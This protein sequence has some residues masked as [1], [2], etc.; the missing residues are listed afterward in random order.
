MVVK[1]VY[2]LFGFVEM[3]QVVVD[4]YIGQIFI[5]CVVQ[6]YCGDGRIYVVGEIEDY[7][8]VVYLFV[9]VCYGVVDDFCWC[10]QCFIL[11]DI[12]Y[13]MFQYVYILVGVGY[14]WVELYIV[15]VFFFVGYNGEWVVFGVGD[16]YEVGWNCCYFIVVVYLYVQQWFVVC[17]Q[18]IF[19]IV[20]QCVV[21]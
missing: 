1:Y 16:G 19:N 10:L 13:K 4:E 17:G 20:N 14:F 9:N 3:Q 7:F 6:Q 11:V 5:D 8:I 2:Y 15:E 18:G 21:G 12:M